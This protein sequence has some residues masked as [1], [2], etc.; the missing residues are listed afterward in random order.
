MKAWIWLGLLVWS[1][2]ASAQ[3]IRTDSV[4]KAIVPLAIN[5]SLR[6]GQ[7]QEI[8][9]DTLLRNSKAVRPKLIPKKATIYSLILPG[10]GQIYNRDFW[11][12]PLVY[13]GLGAA[14]YTIRWNAL[15]YNDFLQPYLTSVNPDTGLPS[16]K[17]E[18]EVY[19]RGDDE[20]R[21]LTLDQVKRGKTF[22]RR[23]REYGYV[24]L[25]AVYALTAIEANVAAHLKTFDMSEDL[26]FRLEPSTEKTFLARPT[27]G[28]KLVFAFK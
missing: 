9:I 2:G 18:Y 28:V 16:G 20:I 10:A 23:Y 22:Y 3:E 17:T 25:A 5:D 6:P 14:V 21:T 26:T 27:A 24:I 11:K 4:R 7:D 1:V 12:L 15:R 13:G 19:I 8:K